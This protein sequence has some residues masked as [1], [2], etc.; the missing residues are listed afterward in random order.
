MTSELDRFRIRDVYD[1]RF[2]MEFIARKVGSRWRLSLRQDGVER[3]VPGIECSSKEELAKFVRKFGAD[4]ARLKN[5][6]GVHAPGCGC[7]WINHPEG[8]KP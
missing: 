2:L 1:P 6:D 4:F 3:E 5:K 7:E 8:T